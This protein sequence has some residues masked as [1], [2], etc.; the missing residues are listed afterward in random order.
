MTSASFEGVA[1]RMSYEDLDGEIIAID[2]QSG[3]YYNLAG[4]AAEIW[5]HA[6]AGSGRDAIV[7]GA[8]AASADAA[9][10]RHE[11]G[12][13]LDELVALNLIAETGPEGNRPAPFAAFET[14]LIEKFEDMAELIQLD[15]I[16]EV[17]AAGWPHVQV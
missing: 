9:A 5:R 15:P 14:P 10:A 16:H 17:T 12:R 11:A 1:A 4:T 2:F 3:A 8:A 13:F 7:S 6:L